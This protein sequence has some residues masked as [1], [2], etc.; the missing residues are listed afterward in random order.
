MFFAAFRQDY[1]A[2]PALL[3]FFSA[4]FAKTSVIWIPLIYIGTSTHFQLRF[5]SPEALDQQ[6][7]SN[8]IEAG[9]LNGSTIHPTNGTT[10]VPRLRD[11]EFPLTEDH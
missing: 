8:R 3:T 6:T 1:Y 7:G 5:V 2:L 4:C 11:K 10:Q 9:P